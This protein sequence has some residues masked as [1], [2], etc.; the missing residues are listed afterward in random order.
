MATAETTRP[1]GVFDSGVGGI[2][3]LKELY[4]LLPH[5]DYVFYGDSA[6][7][8]YGTRTTADVRNLSFA[9][10]EKLMK[11]N[12]KALVIACNTATSAAV[13]QIRERYP[14]LPVVGLEPAVKPAIERY[15]QQRIAVMATELTLREEKFQKQLNRYQG[16]A[17]LLSVPA[18]DLVEF[19][20]RG[21]LDSVALNAYLTKLLAPLKP[22]SAVVL[23]CTHFPFA[24]P[25]IRKIVGSKP[26]IIDGGPGAA[27][28]LQRLLETAALLNSQNTAGQV[29]FYNS[30]PDPAKIEL[31]QKLFEA[32][33]D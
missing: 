18:P 4:R 11:Q 29:K 12:I 8:P 13:N 5:E 1:I 31:S 19:V 22:V 14:N 2:S 7:A 16:A 26:W 6:N 33:I 3:V 10:V 20:E 30:D 25:A 27:R 9:V 17:K 15:P 28:E 23:G 32:V 24:R 21:E